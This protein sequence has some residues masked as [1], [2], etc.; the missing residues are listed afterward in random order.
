[1]LLDLEH[2]QWPINVTFNLIAFW[3]KLVNLFNHWSSLYSMISEYI[4]PKLNFPSKQTLEMTM[5]FVAIMMK[6]LQKQVRVKTIYVKG[7]VW[8]ILFFASVVSAIPQQRQ[9]Q[10]INV[11]LFQQL[12]YKD[13]IQ[14]PRCIF[15]SKDTHQLAYDYE[16]SATLGKIQMGK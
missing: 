7:V 3:G 12:H 6:F 10:I 16:L 14:K 8:V 2:L 9:N 11:M 15:C 13:C 4:V 1:M 5:F